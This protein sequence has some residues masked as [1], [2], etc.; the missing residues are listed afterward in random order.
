LRASFNDVNL[1][2]ALALR[3]VLC[4]RPAA[5]EASLEGEGLASRYAQ[6]LR[7]HGP[8]RH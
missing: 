1:L 3:L 6:G 2:A 5:V 7:I 8:M 4:R